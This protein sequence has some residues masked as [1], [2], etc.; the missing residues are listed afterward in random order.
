MPQRVSVC[1]T[2]TRTF[3]F[4]APDDMDD[5]ALAALIRREAAQALEG[6]VLEFDFETSTIALADV[7]HS[8]RGFPRVSDDRKRLTDEEVLWA[9]EGEK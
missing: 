9:G 1:V 6:G 4:D 8:S 3:E 5:K 7:K 2:R